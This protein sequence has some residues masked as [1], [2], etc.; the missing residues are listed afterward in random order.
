MG[1]VN[2]YLS[3]DQELPLVWLTVLLLLIKPVYMAS[4]LS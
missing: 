1:K 3:D 4:W 2:N